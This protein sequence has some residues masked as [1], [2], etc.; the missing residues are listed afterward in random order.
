[1]TPI[2]MVQQGVTK[3]LAA[4]TSLHFMEYVAQYAEVYKP[5]T[6]S[7]TVQLIYVAGG[8][9]RAVVAL[10]SAPYLL[11]G[12]R[13]LCRA[14]RLK[15][16]DK[17]IDVNGLP[18]ALLSL[19]SGTCTGPTAGIATK[20][21]LPGPTFKGHLLLMDYV[22]AGDGAV[23]MSN[24]TVHDDRPVVGSRQW[25]EDNPPAAVANQ[26]VRLSNGFFYPAGFFKVDVPEG[27]SD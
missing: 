16:S 24:M 15:T 25:L 17:L 11:H 20:L 1:M 12:S 10:G 26:P 13:S 7:N 23:E 22:I 27:A 5:P 21:E 2:G 8:A 6:T 19:Q 14:D 3:V 9:P 4:D 18:V